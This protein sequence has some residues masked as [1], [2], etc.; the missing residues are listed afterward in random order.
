MV[1]M[2]TPASPNEAAFLN[3]YTLAFDDGEFVTVTRQDG[4]N[5][6]AITPMRSLLAELHLKRLSR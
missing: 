6:I 1:E 5:E 2:K 4:L 3:I